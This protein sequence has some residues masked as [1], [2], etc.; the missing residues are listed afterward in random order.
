[1]AGL[2]TTFITSLPKELICGMI[3]ILL[4]TST[5]VHSYSKH[6]PSYK[7]ANVREHQLIV[8]NSRAF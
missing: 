6:L 2:K 1:M 8:I 4:Y 3:I 7:Q 5:I